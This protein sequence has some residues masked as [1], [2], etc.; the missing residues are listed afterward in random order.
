M[1]IARRTARARQKTSQPMTAQQPAASTA[2]ITNPVPKLLLHTRGFSGGAACTDVSSSRFGAFDE[3][4]A[5]KPCP[6]A[7]GSIMRQGGGEGKHQGGGL[8]RI[9]TP[10]ALLA[11]VSPLAF[12]GPA[13]AQE[14]PVEMP[15]TL[16]EAAQPLGLRSGGLV[17]YPR[18]AADLRHD[19]NLF[20]REEAQAETFAVIRPGVRVQSDWSRHAIRF[21]LGAELRRHFEYKS[22]DS[23]QWA[24]RGLVRLDWAERTTLTA[25]GV[26]ARRVE[27]RGTFGDQST[28]DNGPA[29]YT[30]KQGA[31]QIARS[32]GQLELTGE[33]GI[34]KID[35]SKDAPEDA[36]FDQSLRDVRQQWVRLRV[37]TRASDRLAVFTQARV[38]RTEYEIERS[39]DSKGFSLLAGVRYDLTG[40]LTA[41][42]AAGYVQQDFTD[43]ALGDFKGVDFSVAASW[44]PVARVR[45]ELRG[46]R[47]VERSPLPGVAAVIQTSVEGAASYALTSRVL[48]GLEAGYIRESYRG[49]GRRDTR[50]YAEATARYNFTRSL[51]AFA[52]AGYTRQ[53][54]RGPGARQYDGATFRI[55]LSFAP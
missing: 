47:S 5:S 23:E 20:R 14:R 32:G 11:L 19:T 51:T 2:A 40:R 34:R 25:S 28:L 30:E 55:G 39:R 52:G 41:E 49:I 1:L 50:T 10:A 53:E 22:E 48:A 27:R 35:Y 8:M 16:V 9:N 6:P 45:A 43:P 24:A 21:D 29:A 13:L 4:M 3:L 18:I 46:A 54:A 38:N 33:L 17:I 36:P 7:S 12:A 42:A 37:G 44:T 31:L 15:E 26:L